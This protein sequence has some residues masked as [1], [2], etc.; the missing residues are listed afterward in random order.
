MA[1]FEID[2]YDF[3][4]DMHYQACLEGVEAAEEVENEWLQN[5]N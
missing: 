1:E 5:E 3:C 2:A 4:L